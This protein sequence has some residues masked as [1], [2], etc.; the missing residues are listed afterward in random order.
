LSTGSNSGLRATASRAAVAA[1]SRTIVVDV[2]RAG[3][4]ASAAALIAVRIVP[5][6]GCETT[7]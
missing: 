6:L 2:L 7:R 5:S 1:E 3:A 4:A